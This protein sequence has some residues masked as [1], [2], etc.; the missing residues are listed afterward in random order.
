[1]FH[2]ANK[3]AAPT[4]PTLPHQGQ[5]QTPPLPPAIPPTTA[6]Q[7]GVPFGVLVLPRAKEAGFAQLNAQGLMV[8]LDGIPTK[9]HP[10]VPFATAFGS[11]FGV[12]AHCTCY[13]ARH[14][15]TKAV[16]VTMPRMTIDGLGFL[17][18]PNVP[19]DL[20]VE[21]YGHL[22]A[23]DVDLP[24]HTDWTDSERERVRQEFNIY[25]DRFP[26]LATPTVFY[27]T[28]HGYRLVWALSE[29]V[30]IYGA[31]GLAD[32]LGG[33][34]ATAVI[35]G[36][37]VDP[38]C[39]DWGR[40]FRLPMVRR[41]DIGKPA[42]QSNTQP[43]FR[44]SWGRVDFDV[45]ESA[46]AQAAVFHPSAFRGLS[47]YT[48]G[49][50]THS[51]AAKRLAEKLGGR[52]GSVIRPIASTI[53]DIVVGDMPNPGEVQMYTKTSGGNL[54][55]Y[56]LRM[57]MRL[58]ALATPPLGKVNPFAWLQP[59]AEFAYRVLFDEQPLYDGAE[60]GGQGLHEGI[61]RL[62][63]ALCK[64]LRGDLGMQPGNVT[65]QELDAVCLDVARQ[66][67][68][69]RI[70]PESDESLHVEVWKLVTYHFKVYCHHALAAEQEK[71]DLKEVEEMRAATHIAS[72]TIR[73]KK[74]Q[75]QL[76]SWTQLEAAPGADIP[77]D[78]RDW[79]TKG[80][81]KMLII[82][83]EKY[84]RSVLQFTPTGK[85]VYSQP[86]TKI[87]DVLTAIRESGHPIIKPQELDPKTGVPNGKFMS[88]S[89]LM[90]E[91]GTT[92]QSVDHSRL[93]E[94]SVL[95]I[96]RVGESLK[97]VLRLAL[98]GMKKSIPPKY[99]PLVAEWL[100]YLGGELP[101][102]LLDWLACYPRIDR[103]TCG[104]Y[105]QG[106]QGIGKGLLGQ[107]L[108]YMT[109]LGKY[110][111]FQAILESFQDTMF[112]SPLLWGDEDATTSARSTK[113]VMNAYKQVVSGDY[114][115]INP[116][117]KTQTQ[118]EGHWRVFITS[119]SDE[120]IKMDE[121]LSETH[122]GAVIV[123]T[124]HIRANSK[125]C[126]DFLDRIGARESKRTGD[127][128][129]DEY[130]ESGSG[131][132]R[133]VEEAIPRHITWL[134]QNREVKAGRRFLVEGVRTDFHESL[135]LN[136]ATSV[137]VLRGLAKLLRSH[138]QNHL[139]VVIQDGQVY[140]SVDGLLDAIIAQPTFDK[141]LKLAQRGVLR[142]VKRMAAGTDR[143]GIW[144]KTGAGK[145]HTRRMWRLEKGELW[146]S[147]NRVED[148][149]RTTL[150]D[151]TWRLLAP[152]NEI[153]QADE[154]EIK[155]N[156]APRIMPPTSP[157]INGHVNGHINGH[158]KSLMDALKPTVMASA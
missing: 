109:M 4:P 81:R 64:C 99:D 34:I 96:I 124:L 74:I 73:D 33:L 154:D 31:R 90:F 139:A 91:F 46:P 25:V 41:A 39:K 71:N 36:L 23:L 17:A 50:F 149:L 68:K 118:I 43:Y 11:E 119:N 84:G 123:R 155:F 120:F 104:L 59:Y 19:P 102:K 44:A 138:Q 116:K 18:G 145:G 12:D 97:P 55:R 107:A 70:P 7:P 13:A 5:S 115:D 28:A 129:D 85:L 94:N 108:A 98:P 114:N 137:H 58:K 30:T 101:E 117:G 82:S 86:V 78:V 20:S 21:V 158:G 125:K 141:T 66:V 67:N 156:G 146:R 88:E 122:L 14:R 87:P 121:D 24:G 80:W 57:K 83:D 77:R 8:S 10:I 15:D 144:I 150:G 128:G 153:A 151:E 40:L 112:N 89:A 48:P 2:Q 27:T 63:I 103:A 37:E 135:L 47:E 62:A 51:P 1:M 100:S 131:T 157:P 111:K 76:L 79:V 110:A 148:N 6:I 105:I 134:A 113:S 52:I 126:A 133:W 22:I 42:H 136:T 26:L 69:L 130:I 35:A 106:D 95:R 61:G 45:Q 75:D 142:T 54:S 56:K 92:A 9:A 16:E 53:G 147:L 49:E 93:I 38:I 60:R 32:L 72:D 65:A 143:E 29:P 127:D 132:Y 140:V 3:P 152:A